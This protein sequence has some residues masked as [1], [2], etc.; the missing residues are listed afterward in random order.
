MF[1]VD[2][3]F[4]VL[5]LVDVFVAGEITGRPS[6]MDLHYHLTKD[7]IQKRPA[8]PLAIAGSPLLTTSFLYRAQAGQSPADS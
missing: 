1:Y 5:E 2:G 6:Y 7:S 8:R 4:D 3:I